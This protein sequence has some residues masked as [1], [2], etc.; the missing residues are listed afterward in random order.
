MSVRYSQE[1]TSKGNWISSIEVRQQRTG[2][3]P[4]QQL[5]GLAD[6]AVLAKLSLAPQGMT[7]GERH[8]QGSRDPDPRRDVAEQCQTH[9]RDPDGLQHPGKQS[10]GLRTH[11]SHRHEESRVDPIAGQGRG[12][13]RRRTTDQPTRRRNRAVEA[14]MTLRE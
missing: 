13:R 14:R 4:S 3:R 10:D 7:E 9:G 2:A 1:T 5:Q 8:G 12:H 11:G 6:D